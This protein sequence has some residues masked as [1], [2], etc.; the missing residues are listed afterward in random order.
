MPTFVSHGVNLTT[1]G[2]T[3]HCFNRYTY[4]RQAETFIPGGGHANHWRKSASGFYSSGGGGGG[5]DAVLFNE[6]TIPPDE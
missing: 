3:F 4:M 2:A 6:W 5:G 1:P